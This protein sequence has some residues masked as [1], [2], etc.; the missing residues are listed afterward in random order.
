MDSQAVVSRF[1]AEWQAL[2]LMDHP[3]IAKVLDAGTTP[4]GRPY[5]VLELVKG[6]PIT[7]YCD[8]CQLTIRERLKVFVDV[9]RAIQHAHDRGIIHRDVKPSNVLITMQDGRA[10]ASNHRFW[11][12]Q[13]HWS[14]ATVRTDADHWVYQNDGHS[15]VHEP[16]AGR[17][18]SDGRGRSQRRIFP[19]CAALSTS[20]RRPAAV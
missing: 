10:A 3:H 18:Q 9:C 13:G 12:G 20:H 5:F 4:T 2:A 17:A 6:V 14:G 1:R 15:N 11:S 16:G 7:E 19:R 8:S